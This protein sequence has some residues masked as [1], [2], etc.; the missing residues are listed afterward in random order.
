MNELYKVAPN[1]VQK[2]HAYRQLTVSNPNTYYF[3]CDFTETTSQ[4]RIPFISAQN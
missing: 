1:V 2:P 4:T 3:L